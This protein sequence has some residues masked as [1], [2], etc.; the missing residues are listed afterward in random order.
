MQQAHADITRAPATRVPTAPFATFACEGAVDDGLEALCA[1]L[2]ARREEIA[3]LIHHHGG[4][5]LRGL[6]ALDSAQ[7]FETAVR[8][9]G[10]EPMEYVGG[11]SPRSRVTGAVM[12]ATEVPPAYSI[13]LHQEMSYM[14][15]GP[16]RIAFWCETPAT[17][18]GYTTL[19]DARRV[20]AA[21]DPALVER[22]RQKGVQLRRTL[23]SSS[24]LAMKP[25]IPKTWNETFQTDDCAAVERIAAEKGW[26]AEWLESGALM[27]WQGVVP[28]LR[29]H[30]VTGEEV[31][32]NQVPVFEPH[33]ALDWARRDGRTEDAGKIAHA[34]YHDPELLDTLVLGEG[35]PIGADDVA[36]ILAALEENTFFFRW[37]KGDLLVLD[38]ILTMHGRTAFT[39]TRRLLTMLITSPPRA[40]S[41]TH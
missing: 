25:G 26:R 20:L 33:A 36:A 31:W 39:G 40:S 9:M 10:G 16:D 13:P 7:A 38:N 5:L 29:R 35:E 4:V 37:E 8:A 6:A 34:L 24:Q 21:L 2:R 41:R 32:F 18:Q 12:T 15:G 1:K 17:G 19:A 27:L 23:V 28:G 14:I 3:A 22:F 11:T 30:P